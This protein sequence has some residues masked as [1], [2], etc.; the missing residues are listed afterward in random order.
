MSDE[1]ISKLEKKIAS[2][3][4]INKVL[5]GRVERSIDD[6]GDAYSIFERNIVL[7]QGIEART[8]ELEQRNQELAATLNNLQGA[9]DQLIQSEKMAA[10]GS[11][12]AGVAHE[13]N[14]PL[15]I[16][17]TAASHFQI[18]TREF[19]QQFVAGSMKKSDLTRFIASCEESSSII[20]A[21]L[22][23]A[24]ELVNS[25]KKIA[26]DT[27]SEQMQT[28]NLREY[29]SSIIVTLSP[30]IK[31]TKIEV[32]I[33]C[34]GSMWIQTLPGS[35]SQIITNLVINSLVHAFSGEDR[36]VIAFSI[37]AE[38]E[39]CQDLSFIYSDTGKGIAPEHL[40]KIFEPFFTTRRGQG[41]SGLGLHLVYNI[42]T[43]N[44]KGSVTC[45]SVLGKG[46]RFI[47][48]FPKCV[49]Q[50]MNAAAS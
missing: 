33:D 44:L 23:R 21:N 17:L 37:K 3:E 38:G 47:M 36:G 29:L 6:S 26:V 16:G 14:T 13:V 43:K 11:L 41:G 40:S 19:S 27:T 9:T 24:A 18:I 1:L 10:L 31:K 34:P 42:I 5:M 35:F 45:E 32:Q 12:V 22:M 48:V 7:Q 39:N 49:T 46:A 2:L 20:V 28:I 25:F 15:G 4:R 8:K 50:P 30:Q